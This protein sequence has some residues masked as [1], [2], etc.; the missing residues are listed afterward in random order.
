MIL[1]VVAFVV[2]LVLPDAGM[3]RWLERRRAGRAARRRAGDLG[4]ADRSAE[5]RG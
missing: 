5:D 4:S 3:T 1:D 2:D